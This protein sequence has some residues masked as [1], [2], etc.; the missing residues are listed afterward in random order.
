MEKQI[1]ITEYF[2]S[3]LLNDGCNTDDVDKLCEV[4]PLTKTLN[5]DSKDKQIT[6]YSITLFGMLA[7][8]RQY[9]GKWS[10]WYE[11]TSQCFSNIKTDN[12]LFSIETASSNFFKIKPANVDEEKYL[13]NQIYFYCRDNLK[14]DF[15]CCSRYMECSDNK[16]CVHPDLKRAVY[17]NYRKKLINGIIFYGKN[18][19]ID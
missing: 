2:K 13:L 16:K 7:L 14:Y 18:R 11:I 10:D 19:N 4:I 6:G 3:L 8:R 1:F 5:K 17:C 9:K 15:D 12:H